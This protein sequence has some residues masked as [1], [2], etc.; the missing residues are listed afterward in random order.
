[1]NRIAQSAEKDD[2]YS[3]DEDSKNNSLSGVNRIEYSFEC[4]TQ[5]DKEKATNPEDQDSNNNSGNGTNPT[6][7][8]AQ[9]V[10]SEVSAPEIAAKFTMPE[11]MENIGNGRKKVR[12]KLC[13]ENRVNLMEQKKCD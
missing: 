8:S 7:C 3:E 9:N 4:S 6:E 10:V 12:C 2:T 13:F 1:M 11:S 5:D